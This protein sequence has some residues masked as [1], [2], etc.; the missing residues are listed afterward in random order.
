MLKEFASVFNKETGKRYFLTFPSN[1]CKK[2]KKRFINNK[3][4][5]NSNYRRKNR[6]DWRSTKRGK[7]ATSK[8]TQKLKNIMYVLIFPTC[9]TSLEPQKLV[10]FGLHLCHINHK[11]CIGSWNFVLMILGDTSTHNSHFMEKSLSPYP[12][13][14]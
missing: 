6:V 8:R 13:T 14:N 12:E 11:D 7:I 1:G 5:V 9:S 2:E 4:L 10:I 3:N